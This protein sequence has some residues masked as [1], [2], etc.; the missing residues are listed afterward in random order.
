MDAGQFDRL[1]K[2][3]QAGTDRRTLMTGLGA[4]VLAILFGAEESAAK[5]KHHPAK[6]QRHQHHRGHPMTEQRQVAD[7]N[8]HRNQK[9][10]KQPVTASAETCLPAGHRCKGKQA[11]RCCDGLV[12]GART[13]GSA[14]RCRRCAEGTVFHNGACCTPDNTAACAGKTCGDVTNNCGQTVSCGGPCT[15]PP[16]G[17][18]PDGAV[19][20]G[21]DCFPACCPGT[22]APCYSGPAGTNNV[23]ICQAGVRQC[24]SNG[25]WG[26]CVGEVTPSTE[27]C[28]G[29]DYDCDGTVDTGCEPCATVCPAH[30]TCQQGV[31]RGRSCSPDKTISCDCSNLNWCS[32]HGCCTDTCF[33][34]CDAGWFG[35][36]CDEQPIR[37]C[38]DNT[39]CGTCLEQRSEGCTWCLDTSD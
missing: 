20:C 26:A 3:L 18:C 21:N 19:S 2:T 25:T 6:A 7:E 16:P 12:C 31:C 9:P 33:C 8:H 28:D 10:G 23:G 5:R 35:A 24:Q 39:T 30:S 34:R 13:G 15:P 11:T 32:G 27:R 29:H 37:S 17:G 14:R 1:A 4:S 36:A 22:S 38:S